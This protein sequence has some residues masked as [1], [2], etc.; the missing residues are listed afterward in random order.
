[1]KT[2]LFCRMPVLKNA[3]A[4]ILPS[5][6]GLVGGSLIYMLAR[7]V[8]LRTVERAAASSKRKEAKLLLFSA[9]YNILS[10]FQH[11]HAACIPNISRLACLWR[12]SH[13]LGSWNRRSCT[14]HVRVCACWLRLFSFCFR[15]TAVSSIF[16]LARLP[17]RV[18]RVFR[19]YWRGAQRC[20]CV[21]VPLARSARRCR[22]PCLPVA[23]PCAC[24]EGNDDGAL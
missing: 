23:Q 21:R 7:H 22:S 10:T 15:I 4:T 20:A 3:R 1:M 2:E 16:R 17:L 19:Y 12:F 14:A 8:G 24:R 5:L 6:D 18:Y 13:P 9:V 11:Y